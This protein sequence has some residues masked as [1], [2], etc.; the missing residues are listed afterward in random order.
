MESKNHFLFFQEKL[1][2]HSS[3]IA[4]DILSL[5]QERYPEDYKGI[6]DEDKKNRIQILN[7]L[8]QTIA[9]NLVHKDN[10]AA[11]TKNW[12][13][14]I[15]E[16]A[17]KKHFQLSTYLHKMSVYKEVIWTFI[18]QNYQDHDNSSSGMIEIFMQVD[19][20]FNHIIHGFS[21]AF[22]KD[23]QRRMNDYEEKYL[24]LS[25]PIVPVKDNVAIL[26]IIG[27]IDEKRANVLIEETLNEVNQLNIDWIVIDL[28]GVYNVDDLFMNHLQKLLESIIILGITPILTG[29]RPEFSMRAR[30][31]GLNIIQSKEVITKPNLKQAIE[32]LQ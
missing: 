7:E 25:T 3:E 4:Q 15:G 20:L 18:D 17:I 23:E 29:I 13:E 5:L 1:L 28:S 22:S 8:V 16:E 31:M 32:M 2:T 11:V 27:E 26:P 9:N 6:A 10:T 24:K 19:H 30:Q 14:Y 21:L 12:G